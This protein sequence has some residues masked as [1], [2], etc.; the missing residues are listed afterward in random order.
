MAVVPDGDSLSGATPTP[1]PRIP[2]V[3]LPPHGHHH[4]LPRMHHTGSPP[5]LQLRLAATLT[6]SDSHIP[7]NPRGPLPRLAY[8]TPRHPPRPVDHRPPPR[9]T[10][11]LMQLT[12][13]RNRRHVA[14]LRRRNE[15]HPRGGGPGL[16]ATMR[17]SPLDPANLA[18]TAAK[19]RNRVN[20]WQIAGD[21]RSQLNRSA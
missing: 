8:T 17:S 7:G 20:R 3:H 1:L 10:L 6:P 18:R 14:L 12:Q 15:R 11:P 21:L 4:P 5:H 2:R 16:H 19:S 13:R 9:P